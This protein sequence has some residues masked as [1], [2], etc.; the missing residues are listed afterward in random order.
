MARK[1]PYADYVN[2][3]MQQYVRKPT[4]PAIFKT[5]VDKKNWEACDSVMR[6]YMP[7]EKEILFSVYSMNDTMSD[8]IYAVSKK[9]DV[10]Q[11]QVRNLIRDCSYRIAK[12]RGLI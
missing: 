10:C 9:L 6:V 4:K 11:D 1:P 5:E 2:H 8:I 7:V 3:C 12:R